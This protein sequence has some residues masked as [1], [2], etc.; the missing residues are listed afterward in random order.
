MTPSVFLSLI[1]FPLKP[2]SGFICFPF[3]PYTLLGCWFQCYFS[4]INKLNIIASSSCQYRQLR[5]SFVFLSGVLMMSGSH[6][7][8]LSKSEF[9]L[10]SNGFSLLLGNT[11]FLS[12]YSL[13]FRIVLF[14]LFHSSWSDS[15]HQL[16]FLLRQIPSSH[17]LLT[18]LLF[19]SELLFSFT[20]SFL[21]HTVSIVIL[22]SVEGLV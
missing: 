9:S 15:C 13:S 8:M 20:V 18:I 17:N 11:Q 1:S 12:W 14:S 10:I 22:L 16:S 7:T 3:W 5:V 6:E 21:L 19:E 2:S 4:R